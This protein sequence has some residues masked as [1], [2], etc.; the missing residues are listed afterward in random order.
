MTDA[1]M[2]AGALYDNRND[3]S[4]WEESSTDIAVTPRKSEVISFRLPSDELDR[5]GM[6]ASAT[7]ETISEFVRAALA[8][9]MLGSRRLL[10]EFDLMAGKANFLL[11]VELKM[12][13][14]NRAEAEGQIEFAK[15]PDFPP[16]SV[17]IN[18]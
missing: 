4:M 13:S 5:L 18:G 16:T 14:S 8:E 9:R 7:G 12:R 2:D 6:A 11:F 1:D 17:S 10:P 3:P 15:V